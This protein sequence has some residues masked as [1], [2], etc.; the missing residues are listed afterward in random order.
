MLVDMM[1]VHHAYEQCKTCNFPKNI[2]YAWI[3]E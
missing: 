2:V 3:K 1:I